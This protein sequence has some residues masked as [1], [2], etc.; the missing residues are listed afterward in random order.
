[1]TTTDKRIAYDGKSLFIDGKREILFGGEVHYFRIPPTLWRDRLEK[2]KRCGCNFIATY[3]PW[4]WHETVEGKLNW[5]GDRDLGR[6]LQLCREIGLYVVI[7]PGPYICAEWDFGGFPDWLLGRGLKLRLPDERYYAMVRKWYAA[8]GQVI[9]PHLVTRGGN[10]ILI[11]IE[12]EYDHLIEM[13]EEFRISKAEAQKYLLTLL[14]IVREL[15]IDIPAFTNEGR[16]ILGTEIINTYT[17][18]PN[19]PMIWMWEFNDFDR[20]LEESKKLQPDKPLMILE[21]ETGWFAQFGQKLYEAEFELTE[22]ITKTILTYGSSLTNF[23]MLAGGTTMPY[24]H[25]KGDFGGIGT[26]TTF[27]FGGVPIRE[28]GDINRKYHFLRTMKYFLDDFQKFQVTSDYRWSY[29]EVV[30][31]WDATGRLGKRKAW[32]AAG[33]EG[34][35][36]N[37]KVLQRNSRTTGFILARN[38]ED[39]DKSLR[40]RYT[41]P[42]SAKKRVLPISGELKLLAKASVMLPI[43]VT[44]P[45][46]KTTI[47]HATSEVTAI[48][49]IGERTIVFLKGKAEIGGEMLLAADG[50]IKVVKGKAQATRAAGGR[51]L[52]YDHA[53]ELVFTV[54]KTTFLVQPETQ[55]EK[56]W[57]EPGLALETDLNYLKKAGRVGDRTLLAFEAKP[58]RNL[59][60]NV[61]AD[62][63]IRSVK[64]DGRSVAV[65]RDARTGFARFTTSIP[66]STG[67]AL[68]WLGAWRYRG[69]SAEKSAMPGK[70]RAIAANRSLEA[71]RFL[72]HGY[73]WYRTDITL[74]AKFDE[75]RL[76]VNSNNMDRFTVYVNGAFRW[77]GIGSPDL[78]ITELLKR[79]RNAITICYDN[80]FHTKAHPH[81]GPVQ[82]LSGLFFPVELTGK[83]GGRKFR[84]VVKSWRLR[85]G[86]GGQTAG[87][88]KPDLKEKGWLS[89]APAPKYVLQ[90]D[91]GNL[92]WF[93]RWFSYA[94]RAGWKAPVY[95]RIPALRDRCLIYLN[96]TLVGKYEGVGPQDKFYLP[97][98]LLK[99]RNLVALMLEGPGFHPVKQFGFIPAWFEELELGTYYAAKEMLVEI[100]HETR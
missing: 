36:E 20:K 17:Y 60:T 34:T 5:S 14:K 73:Y 39:D 63:P 86:L 95:L 11:Q 83:A 56:L 3:V 30:K 2:V 74:P 31:G 43:A 24:W 33:P 4:N 13:S 76:K 82:K 19:I 10:V 32:K 59:A 75:M 23:Y 44:I 21:L 72:D 81:E 68:K 41:V 58:G 78:E 22:A 45:G 54:G 69:D 7:K 53:R 46:T 1:M 84:H 42:G 98:N 71:A 64:V 88:M 9:K 38:L 87:F 55:V 90:E 65:K 94:P 12:N 80:A 28:W 91:L 89:A 77:I 37:V 100:E 8:V 85:P 57:L 79:G 96:G 26:C 62:R 27:D 66:S 50:P 25:C 49:A 52:R 51:L 48:R 15:G 16:C 92:V 6:F 93:R 99:R 47:A 61:L 67:A 70:W 40:I 18:Y 35:F 29:A 97:E